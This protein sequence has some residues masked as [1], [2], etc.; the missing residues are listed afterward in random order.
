MTP[1][2]FRQAALF[3]LFAALLPM[4]WQPSVAESP[5]LPMVASLDIQRLGRPEQL[6]LKSESVLVLDAR[7]QVAFVDRISDAPRPIASLTK[8][9]TALVVLG[10]GLPLDEKLA[11]TKEDRDRLKGT[12]SKLPIGGEFTRL[13]LLRAALA[14]SDNRA[15]AALARHYPGG[16]SAFVAA[17]NNRA[18]ALGMTRTRFVDASG[19]SPHNQSTAA[20]LA[21]LAL[22]LE[23]EPLIASLSTTER[24]TITN[25]ANRRPIALH[26]TNQ[27]LYGSQ[28]QIRLSK[29]G[30][31][32]EAGNCLLM[33]AAVD[34][35]P[36]I[37]VLLNSWGKYSKYGDSQRIRDW[38]ARTERRLRTPVYTAGQR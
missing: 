16:T 10:P 24:Y 22:A 37:I 7:D 27:L 36:V 33:N 23:Q 8:L 6:S 29:T 35:R 20:D 28:W 14:S 19:L 5:T 38:L 9:M 4:A 25:H 3:G 31:T 21:R 32:S 18:A 34:G 2:R 26:N 13:D 1:H 11:I 15:A 30:Y 17:M 12:Q